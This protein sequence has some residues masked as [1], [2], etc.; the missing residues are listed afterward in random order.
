MI[1][2]A[3]HRDDDFDHLVAFAFREKKYDNANRAPDIKSI[4]ACLLRYRRRQK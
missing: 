2:R 3:T 4:A 1:E